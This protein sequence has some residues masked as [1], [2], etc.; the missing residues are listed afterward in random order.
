MGRAKLSD[1]SCVTPDSF[2]FGSKHCFHSNTS[3]KT[4]SFLRVQTAGLCS[5]LLGDVL[6]VRKDRV[7]DVR[8]GTLSRGTT[9]GTI[10]HGLD[11]LSGTGVSRR[12]QTIHSNFSVSVLP[13]SLIAFKGR[14]RGLLRSLRGRSRGVFVIAVLIIRTTSDHRGLRGLVCSTGNV[15]GARGYSL[16]QLSCR[17]RRNFMST[18]PVNVGRIRV[19]HKLAADKATV[20]LPFHTYRMFRPGNI[21][22]KLG[23]AAGQVVLTSH[24]ALGYPGKIILNAPNSNGSFDYGQRTTSICLRA[25]SSLLFLSPR[26]RCASLYRRLSKRIVQLTPSDRSCVGPL[27]MS[28]AAGANRGPLLV[29]TSFVVS[30]YRLVL[31]T[32][33]NNLG[34]VRGSIVSHYVPGVCH[35]LVGSPEP[36]GVPV[37]KS[38][39]RYLQTRRRRRTRR[40]TATLRLCIFNS[41]G[42]LG[43]QAG[44][45]ISGHITYC[46]V[47]NLKRGLGGPNVLAIRGGV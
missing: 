13:P 35:R 8:T 24:G 11:S 16:V 33:R 10:G 44:I 38:L 23:T 28:L 2:F 47:D 27:S 20:F 6:G 32:T 43:R 15:A 5:A 41:L 4:I 9:L 22:C 42:C 45:G 3:F 1:G 46:S 21:C 39:C 17:R 31:S 19:R 30:F 14:T 12:G 29:G 40:L 7:I 18:L 36:R 25:A 37:L 34:P 26:G